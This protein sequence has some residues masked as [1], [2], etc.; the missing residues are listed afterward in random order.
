MGVVER[1]REHHRAE[2][3]V[4]PLLLPRNLAL[5]VGLVRYVLQVPNHVRVAVLSV[6][7]VVIGVGNHD[8]VCVEDGVDIVDVVGVV[9][10]TIVDDVPVVLNDVPVAVRGAAV[11]CLLLLLG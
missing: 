5:L 11:H 6:V 2:K 9:D 3:R 8:V 1:V 10:D 4:V 7:L